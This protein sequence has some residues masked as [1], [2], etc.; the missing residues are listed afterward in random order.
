MA[1]CISN[2]IP[3]PDII[4]ILALVNIGVCLC[5]TSPQML[6]ELMQRTVTF[7]LIYLPQVLRRF[8]FTVSMEEFNAV[9][10]RT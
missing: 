9:G 1:L 10:D 2:S 3:I 7:P 6:E 4:W 8:H 5:L